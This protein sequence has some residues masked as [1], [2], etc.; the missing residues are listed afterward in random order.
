MTVSDFSYSSAK[1]E[2]RT[3]P[4]PT[5]KDVPTMAAITASRQQLEYVWQ[6]LFMQ[7]STG[8]TSFTI[9]SQVVTAI[10]ADGLQELVDRSRSV[11]TFPS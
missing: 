3:S 9:P 6:S 10:G 4:L 11:L 7:I 2:S 1:P 8:A 5:D